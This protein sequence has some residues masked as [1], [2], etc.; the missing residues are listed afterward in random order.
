MECTI[1]WGENIIDTT[2]QTKNFKDETAAVEWIRKHTDKVQGI[3]NVIIPEAL[4]PLNH[5]LIVDLLRG[6]RDY[7]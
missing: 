6:N 7:L 4:K 1:L 2:W 5:F 3:N